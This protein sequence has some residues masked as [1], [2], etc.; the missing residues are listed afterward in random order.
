MKKSLFF[1]ALAATVLTSCK[2]DNQFVNPQDNPENAVAIRMTMNSPVSVS[3]RSTGA[4]GDLANTEGNVWNGQKLNVFMLEQ[5]TLQASTEVFSVGAEEPD[6]VVLFYDAEVTAPVGMVAGEVNYGA[7]VK[8]YPPSGVHNFFA[9]H[10]DDASTGAVDTL[11]GRIVLPIE[12]DG[13]QDLMVAQAIPSSA[14]SAKIDVNKREESFYSAYAARRGVQPSF[15]FNHLLS[16]LVFN[17]AAGLEKATGE[18]GVRIDSIVVKDVQYKGSMEV[19]A[20]ELWAANKTNWLAL[21]ADKKDFYLQQRVGDSIKA[22]EPNQELVWDAENL[23]K[24]DS[25]NF[26]GGPVFYG[27]TLRIGESLLL[28]PTTEAY[29]LVVYYSQMPNCNAVENAYAEAKAD[30]I[31]A[32]GVAPDS[33]T[34]VGNWITAFNAETNNN[35]TYE[36]YKNRLYRGVLTANLKPGT[37][38]FEAGKQYNVNFTIFGLEEIKLSVTLTGWEEGGDFSFDNDEPADEVEVELVVQ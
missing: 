15:T 10:D 34:W 30:S 33:T 11:A 12:I 4:V 9:Y 17:A 14:D 13:S 25:Q 2:K 26:T 38:G 37:K 31:A 28:P 3:T 19:A 16:R 36:D 7:A 32:T 5:G 23:G 22:L 20:T 8:Y 29:K 21:A 6:S 24:D 1:V 18:A 35:P 27:D